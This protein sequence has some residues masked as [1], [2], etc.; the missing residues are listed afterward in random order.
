MFSKLVKSIKKVSSIDC[1]PRS[2]QYTRT[3]DIGEGASSFV[4][5]LKDNRTGQK[6]A[7]KACKFDGPRQ[8][9]MLENE[10]NILRHIA[11]MPEAPKTLLHA[12]AVWKDEE[13]FF[14]MTE[15]FPGDVHSLVRYSGRLS[16]PR[17]RLIIA[18]LITAVEALH[19]QCIIHRDIKP[20]NIFLTEDLN[21]VLG[22]FG[23]AKQFR[24]SSA[25]VAPT[26]GSASHAPSVVNFTVDPNA[27]SGSFFQPPSDDEVN[28]V[29]HEFAGTA[30]FLSPEQWNRE[31]YSFPTDIFSMGVVM[32]ELCAGHMPFWQLQRSKD[33]RPLYA[34][35]ERSQLD[36]RGWD[37]IA[38]NL[39]AAMMHPSQT[40]RYTLDQVKAHP[41]FEGA[42][43]AAI[44]RH[45]IPAAWMCSEFAP[46]SSL[47]PTVKAKP[48]FLAGLFTKSKKTAPKEKEIIIPVPPSST[49]IADSKV[50][51]ESPASISPHDAASPALTL[52]ALSLSSETIQTL[53]RA[54]R[55]SPV[56]RR[57]LL[58]ALRLPPCTG[59][60]PA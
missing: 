20:E 43:W 22:D 11:Q 13:H 55:P 41:Y 6:F 27:V 7:V 9:L 52:V 3:C 17:T 1:Q 30:G 37:P 4:S 50:L 25:P 29:A 45:E 54:P 44:S 60:C 40:Q 5:E 33:H 8:Q 18:Q 19:Q 59:N 28:C 51:H 24:T 57:P 53:L 12:K 47:A 32:H 39:V 23:L 34:A 31:G 21:A 48:A 38:F 49:L 14:T 35:Y 36:P 56:L 58:S 42:D 26:R 10:H 46:K 16:G 2:S 15:R